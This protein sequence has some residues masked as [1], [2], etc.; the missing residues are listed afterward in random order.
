MENQKPKQKR[1]FKFVIRFFLFI[2]ALVIVFFTSFFITLY[3][4]SST[5]KED[6]SAGVELVSDLT[7]DGKKSP[8]T[9]KSATEKNSA[10]NVSEPA[11]TAEPEKVVNLAFSSVGKD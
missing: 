10:E 8:Q 11:K 1:S 6:I 2:F 3:I 4:N 5:P 7:E 9:S